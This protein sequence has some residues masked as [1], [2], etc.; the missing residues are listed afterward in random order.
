MKIPLRD[1]N[2]KVDKE[3]MFKPTIGNESLPKINNKISRSTE[4]SKTKNNRARR[5]VT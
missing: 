3:N 1:F 5:R 4:E 2:V